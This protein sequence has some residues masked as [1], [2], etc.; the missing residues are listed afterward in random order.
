[1]YYTMYYSF[2]GNRRIILGV[3]IVAQHAHSLRPDG[4]NHSLPP[5]FGCGKP[6]SSHS[7]IIL[8]VL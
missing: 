2:F 5:S 7:S 8:S 6:I 3:M 4:M 1:M